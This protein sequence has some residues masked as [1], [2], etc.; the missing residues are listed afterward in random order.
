LT[1]AIR[2]AR[3]CGAAVTLLHVVDVNLHTPPTGPANVERLQRE[4]WQK[5]RL[6]LGQTVSKL[7][8]EQVEVQ[9]LIREGLSW[10]E[11]VEAARD[12]DLI[13]IGQHKRKRF[14]H[15]FSRHTVQGVLDAAPCPVL[16]IGEQQDKVVF[17]QRRE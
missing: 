8:E 14:W 2:L 5:G 11:I 15:L 1:K 4:L 12:C 7:G 6:Q 16:V 3:Q 9:T 10:E 13:V 17:S